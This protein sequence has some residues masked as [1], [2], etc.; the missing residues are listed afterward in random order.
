MM[1]NQLKS[2]ERLSLSKGVCT[3]VLV[4][5]LHLTSSLLIVL[6]IGSNV[7]EKEPTASHV[8]APLPP[9]KYLLCVADYQLHSTNWRWYAVQ[10]I[11]P[12]IIALPVVAHL[13]Y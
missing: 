10:Y 11:R 2:I 5:N 1:R 4:I 6:V 7:V 13:L 8:S 3:S 12:S 9:C